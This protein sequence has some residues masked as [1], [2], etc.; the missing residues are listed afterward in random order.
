MWHAWRNINY[1]KN[2]VGIP[3]GRPNKDFRVLDTGGNI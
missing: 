1:Y 2:L 3:Q